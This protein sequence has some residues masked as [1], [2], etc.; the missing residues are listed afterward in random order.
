M[1][2]R[3]HRDADNYRRY[4][5]GMYRQALSGALPPDRAGRVLRGLRIVRSWP[6]I[7]RYATMR[8]M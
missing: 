7:R 2:R 4:A 1:L 3:V 8:R 6:G 5:V